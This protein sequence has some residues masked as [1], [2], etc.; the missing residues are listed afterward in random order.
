MTTI[1]SDALRKVNPCTELNVYVG[2]PPVALPFCKLYKLLS[3]KSLGTGTT[4]L[5]VLP[6][7]IL[8]GISTVHLYGVWKVR[9]GPQLY[10][11]GL[12]HIEIELVDLSDDRLAVPGR[13]IHEIVGL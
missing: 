5:L 1:H 12:I 6:V 8:F 2:D 7:L 13:L 10:R 9:T 4:H 3:C 11:I